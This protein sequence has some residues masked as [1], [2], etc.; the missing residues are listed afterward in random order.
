MKYF[1]LFLMG[2]MVVAATFESDIT[3]HYMQVERLVVVIE[4]PQPD[5]LTK[6][7]VSEIY[8]DRIFHAVVSNEVIY[9]TNTI[10]TGRAIIKLEPEDERRIH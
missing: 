1:A 5:G 6:K 8:L 9:A 4:S 2:A 3:A 10:D 7:V